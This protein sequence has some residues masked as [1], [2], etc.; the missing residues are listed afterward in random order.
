[1]KAEFTLTRESIFVIAF[2]ALLAVLLSMLLS[3]LGPFISSF[4]WATILVMVFYPAYSRFLQW[5][6]ER[7]T[8]SALLATLLVV[9]LLALPGFFVVINL[10]RELPRVYDFLSNS[11][12]DQKSQWVMEKLKFLN[13]EGW[14]QSLGLDSNQTNT[15]LQKSISVNL[16]RLAELAV[17]KVTEAFSD[18]PIFI[19]QAVFVTVAL[20][21]FFRDGSRLAIKAIDFLPMEKAHQKKVVHTFSV[22][23]TAVVRAVFLSALMQGGL[24][25]IGLFLTGVPVPIL[26]GLLAFVNSFIPFLGA[27]SVWIPACIWLLIQNQVLAAAGLGLLGIIMTVLDQVM[28]A[29]LIG[30]EAK[31]PIFWLFFTTIG[32]LKVYGF[33]GIFLGPIIL[34]M[35]IA[36][37]AIYREVYLGNERKGKAS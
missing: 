2:F 31:L 6:G 7:P 13:L 17:V 23:V 22:T 28:R 26:L 9:V 20:F 15:V 21:F 16:Q 36:F 8:L 11:Q 18:V 35:G 3:L 14:A 37:L 32:G 12:W 19:L 25:G 24:T 27:A 4:L 1:M 30:N 33:I 5:T 34:S 10:A 29:W